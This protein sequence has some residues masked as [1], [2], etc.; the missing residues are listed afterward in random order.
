MK[1]PQT[2]RRAVVIAVGIAIATALHYLTSPSLI[3]W[4]EL[5]QRLYYLPIIYA[6]IFFG[7]RGGLVASL[8]SA[9]CYIPHI[10]MAWHHM[11]EYALNQYAEIIVFFLVGTVTGVLADRGRKQRLELETASER[12]AK[13]NRE[14]QDSFEQIK[15]A[16]RLSAIGQLSASLAH[17]IRNPLAAIDGAANLIESPRT[18]EEI[19]NG[20]LAIIHKEIQRLN[21]LL[22]NL[23]DFARPRQPAFRDVEPGRLIDSI[24]NLAGHSAEQKGITLRK[25]VAQQV[26][27]FECDP[28][29]MKQVILNLTI[30][31]VQAMTGPGEVLLSAQQ[32]DSSILVSVRDHGPG[33]DEEN[34]EKIFNPFFTTKETGTGLGLSVVYQ[35]VSQHGGVVKAERNGDGG[36][37]F[38]VVVPLSQRRTV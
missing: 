17:E 12:L 30:N 28:E 32:W 21:K 22:T 24:I 31:A 20:S 23:L 27:A 37:T 16:D 15:R 34:I 35:I 13:V 8:C 25:E 19:R 2:V 10:L 1:D 4:H 14:L 38:S 18:S 11:P 33:V 7:W 36:M 5:F 29:Q 6:A 26:P 9:I 3:L